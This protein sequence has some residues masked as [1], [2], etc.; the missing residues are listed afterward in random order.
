MI[1][2]S[3]TNNPIDFPKA[4]DKPFVDQIIGQALDDVVSHTWTAVQYEQVADVQRRTIELVVRECALIAG[5]MELEGR[6]NIG[7]VMLDRFGV[8]L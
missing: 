1:H 3:N 6:E 4:S 7:A 8:P 2:Y 5:L